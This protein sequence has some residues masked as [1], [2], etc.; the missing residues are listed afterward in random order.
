MIKDFLYH[1]EELDLGCPTLELYY[2]TLVIKDHHLSY[3]SSPVG[4]YGYCYQ[5]VNK[6]KGPTDTAQQRRNKC[7]WFR[8][9]ST[10]LLLRYVHPV[11]R[12]NKLSVFS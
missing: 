2:S 5:S 8:H 12:P 9:G 6:A 3:S 11:I 10:I 4:L 7:L 1:L